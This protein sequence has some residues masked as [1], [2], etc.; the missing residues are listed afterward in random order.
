M[1]LT[2]NSHAATAAAVRGPS[3]AVRWL[4]LVSLPFIAMSAVPRDAPRWVLMW[5]GAFTIYVACKWL[6]WTFWRPTAVSIGRRAAWWMGWPGMD[7]TR[8]LAGKANS[9]PRGGEWAAAVGKTVFG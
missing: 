7:A 5:I 1:A 2:I 6:S 8:F 3:M 9:L 4:A